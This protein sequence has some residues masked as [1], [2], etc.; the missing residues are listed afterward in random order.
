M[1]SRIWKSGT[2]IWAKKQTLSETALPKIQM[3][4]RALTCVRRRIHARNKIHITDE[5]RRVAV[6]TICSTF[7]NTLVANICDGLTHLLPQEIMILAALLPPGHPSAQQFSCDFGISRNFGA[8]QKRPTAIS[9]WERSN[10][11]RSYLTPLERLQP[12]DFTRLNILPALHDLMQTFFE[13]WQATNGQGSPKGL[14]V[15]VCRYLFSIF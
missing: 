8:R 9:I 11:A 6:T 15:N 13:N 4:W 14:R 10:R 7:A 5:T 1:K 2:K 12:H 3:R